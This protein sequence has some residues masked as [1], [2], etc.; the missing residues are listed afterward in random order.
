MVIGIAASRHAIYHFLLVVSSDNIFVLQSCTIS[1]II[2][3]LQCTCYVISRNVE[4]FFSFDKTVKI[5]SYSVRELA[6]L[7]V[8]CRR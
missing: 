3:R 4:K 2:P 8:K 7:C 6:D 1:E 5:T